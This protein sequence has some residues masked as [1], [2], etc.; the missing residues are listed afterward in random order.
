MLEWLELVEVE[1][2]LDG[3]VLAEDFLEGGRRLMHR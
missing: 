2:Q 3:A 1:A